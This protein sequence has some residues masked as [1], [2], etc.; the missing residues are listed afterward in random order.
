MDIVPAKI[1]R[2][3][4]SNPHPQRRGNESTNQKCETYSEQG[5]AS[6]LITIRIGTEDDI[7]RHCS[8]KQTFEQFQQREYTIMYAHVIHEFQG[9]VRQHRAQFTTQGAE[10]I[11]IIWPFYQSSYNTMLAETARSST[12]TLVRTI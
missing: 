3:S 10:S 2:Q 6:V 8:R 4:R 1:V 9:G 7:F 11:S 5:P 12:T